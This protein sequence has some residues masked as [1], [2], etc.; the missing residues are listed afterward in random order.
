V[1]CE[2]GKGNGFCKYVWQAQMF[3]VEG[4]FEMPSLESL[5]IP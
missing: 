5:G 2:K 4:A 3:A 1:V